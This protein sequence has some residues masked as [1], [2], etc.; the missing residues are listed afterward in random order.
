MADKKYI[1]DLNSLI[2]FNPRQRLKTPPLRNAISG[3]RGLA[4][5]GEDE[6]SELVESI[7]VYHSIERTE[8]V[9]SYTLDGAPPTLVGSFDAGSDES[10]GWGA[11]DNGSTV[12]IFHCRYGVYKNN[13]ELIGFPPG[14]SRSIV[15]TNSTVICV[16]DIVDA[17][18][19]PDPIRI[20]DLDGVFIKQISV[21]GTD[22]G[23]R[24]M[25][26]NDHGI[27]TGATFVN[28]SVWEE[29]VHIYDFDGVLLLSGPAAQYG[30]NIFQMYSGASKNAFFVTSINSAYD[31]FTVTVYNA[32]V[33]QIGSFSIPVV[34]IADNVTGV[35]DNRAECICFTDKGAFI[36][37]D[38]TTQEKCNIYG[39]DLTYDVNGVA[40]G[41]T[42]N[43]LIHAVDV[44]ESGNLGYASWNNAA[45]LY[46]R[47]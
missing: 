8:K 16:L 27:I 1:R 42:Y 14:E 25:R 18:R 5:L 39:Y 9:Y 2:R 28:N 30:D 22:S 31:T 17:A 47:A 32:D 38:S 34:E 4:E 36:F 12:D 33:V 13:V 35:S 10:F 19:D 45:E 11:S 29:R 26:A 46:L 44:P 23:Q 21:D 24:F 40:D 3:G 6:V 7:V 43:G 15:S 37:M 41:F 20:Y